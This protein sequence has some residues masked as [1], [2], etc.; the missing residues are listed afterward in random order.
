MTAHSPVLVIGAGIAGLAAAAKL[1][2][3]G[4]SVTIVE[5]RDRIGGRIFTQRDPGF[6]APIELGAEFIHGLPKEIWKPLQRSGVKITEVEGDSWCNS[7]GELSQCSFFNQ[8]DDILEK[9]DA[10]LPDESFLQFLKRRFPDSLNTPAMDEAKKHAISYV[11]G[12]NAADPNL[13]GV[14]WLV[15]EME[16][17]K[18]I[19]G[20][21]AFRPENGYFELVD[22]FRKQF[23]EACGSLLTGTVVERIGWKR[24]HVEIAMHD[25]NGPQMWTAEKVLITLP[26]SLLQGRVGEIGV[27]EFTP[28]IPSEKIDA[29]NKLEMGHVIRMVLRFRHRFWKETTTHSTSKALASMS[30]FLTD[31]ELFPTWWTTM[32]EKL[33]IITGWAPFRSADRLSGQSRSF[34]IEHAL[35]ALA[36]QLRVSRYKLDEEFEAAYFHDWQSDPFSRGAYSYG[37]VGADGAQQALGAPVEDTLFFAGEATDISGHNGTVHGAIRSGYRAAEEILKAISQV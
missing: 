4:A 10:G 5:A 8:V 37:K 20:D 30:F 13:V 2:Q 12:F 18:T 31:D 17:E 36:R 25:A 19:E 7:K 15:Q 9:M 27:I 29:L 28:P 21:R 3:A 22:I 6:D 33:P 32:P 16:A 35:N 24:T 34:V 26:L 14:H 1:A 11:S 23:E